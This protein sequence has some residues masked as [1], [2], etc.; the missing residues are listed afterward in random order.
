V[1]NLNLHIYPSPFKFESRILRETKSIIDFGL[2][3]K[4]IIASGWSE[5]MSE[6]E[7]IDENRSVERFKLFFDKLNKNSLISILKY[8]EFIVKVFTFYKGKKVKVVNCHSLFVLP[9]GYLLKLVDSKIWLIYDAHELESEKAGLNKISKAISS[10]LEKFL[11]KKVDKLIV[12]SPSIGKW[13]E[14]K[15]GVSNVVV[16]RNTPEASNSKVRNSVFNEKFQI[17]KDSMIFIY[18]GVVNKGRGIELLINVFS[19]IA[20]DKHLVIMGYGP[21]V[22]FVKEAER[23]SSNIHFLV[24]VLPSEIFYYTSGADVGLSI[25]ENI[26]LSY[27]YCLPNKLFEYLHSGL[28]VIVSDFPDMSAIINEYNC[29]WIT[30]VSEKELLSTINSICSEDLLEKSKGVVNVQKEIHWEKE[31]GLLFDAFPVVSE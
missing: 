31:S 14:S 4:V 3:D 7:H 9:V 17:S 26:S 11:I 28:P 21:L 24:A 29:G 15:Y 8:F 30:G 2:A 27:Y 10:S 22:D 12:V 6:L 16:I 18:Q 5:G 1:S 25:I 19:E 23:N 13:Y 20:A